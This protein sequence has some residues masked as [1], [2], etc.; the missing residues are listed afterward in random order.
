MTDDEKEEVKKTMTEDNKT[1]AEELLQIQYENPSTNE[2]NWPDARVGHWPLIG[3]LSNGKDELRRQLQ[4][5]ATNN[6]RSST[7]NLKITELTKQEE[8]DGRLAYYTY[9]SGTMTMN[10]YSKELQQEILKN[11][12]IEKLTEEYIKG[13]TFAQHD[14]FMHEKTHMDHDLLDGMRNLAHSPVHAARIER[15]TEVTAYAVQYLTAAYK[16]AYMKSLGITE[17]QTPTGTM[18]IEDILKPYPDLKEYID[19]KGFNLK[20]LDNTRG[21]VQIASEHWHKDRKD[22]YNQQAQTNYFLTLSAEIVDERSDTKFSQQYHL[23]TPE[24]REALYHQI[25]EEMLK[26]IDIGYNTKIDLTH[27]KDLLNTMSVKEAKKLDIEDEVN[28]ANNC[29]PEEILAINTHLEKLGLKTDREKD[30]YMRDFLIKATSRQPDTDQELKNIMLTYNNT[31]V[32][33]DNIKSMHYKNKIIVK[34]NQSQITIPQTEQSVQNQ[35][36]IATTKSNSSSHTT[37][38]AQAKKHTR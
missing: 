10:T 37:I 2:E 20:D 38:L 7:Q 31:I 25:S 11:P 24:N 36:Q 29:N 13:N 32:Y 35:Q 3:S 5:D 30:E 26:D 4:E 15:Q 17:T 21:I 27:C 14:A 22:Y 19:E 18:P 8:F 34:S 1:S 12:N 33:S 23:C 16:Y 6:R 9:N 28:L